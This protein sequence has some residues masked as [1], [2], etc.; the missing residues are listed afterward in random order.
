ENFQNRALLV[1]AEVARVEGRVLDAERLYEAAI[2][3]ARENGFVQNEALANELA[4]RFY[5]ARGFQTI[6]QAYLRNARYGYL[7]WGADGKVRQ[8]E[9]RHPHLVEADPS[10]DPT[11]TA[12]TP[13]E[14][15]DLAVVL[16]VLGTVSGET[17]LAKLIAT[18]MR[19]GLEQAG[20]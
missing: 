8:L 20:A 16:Q 3:S 9:Q 5:A 14:Q 17:D 6:S 10:V 4:A 13:V 12:E 19:L 2:Q 18:V 15:L 11:R 7:R 1:G